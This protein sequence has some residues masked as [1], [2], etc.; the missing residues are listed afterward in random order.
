[1]LKRSI[2]GESNHVA[3]FRHYCMC[4]SKGNCTR[5]L[6]EYWLLHRVL[7][8]QNRQRQAAK[9]RRSVCSRIIRL[10]KN[11]MKSQRKASILT[12]VESD[13]KNAVAIVKIV[14]Q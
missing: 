13:D 7:I 6:C 12:K 9:S 10:K 5:S 8:L 3:I 2:E 4:Y 11:Q 1:M 14:P